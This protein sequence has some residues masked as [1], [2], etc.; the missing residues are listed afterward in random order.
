MPRRQGLR[1]W[2]SCLWRGMWI[3][4]RCK[5]TRLFRAGSIKNNPRLQ[6]L[7]DG[8]I[9]AED[10]EFEWEIVQGATTVLNPLF[11]KVLALLTLKDIWAYWQSYWQELGRASISKLFLRLL[12][13]IL[14][15]SPD[16]IL[17]RTRKLKPLPY[18]YLGALVAP[19][20]EIAYLQLRQ[21]KENSFD[22]FE[23]SLSSYLMVPVKPELANLG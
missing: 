19:W 3:I 11:I 18:L 16:Q 23:F 22:L 7:L 12:L 15:C 21:I 1:R 2:K 20:R 13:L 14:V 9:Q 17:L 6:T 8:S 4:S 5:N 10:I